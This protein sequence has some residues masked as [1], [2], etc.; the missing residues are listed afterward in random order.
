M[1]KAD[2][3]GTR[4]MWVR[5][6]VAVILLLLPTAAFAQ[7]EKRIALLIGNKNYQPAVGALKNPHNDIE[8][9]SAALDAI[10]FKDRITH[11]DLRRG[12]LL[13]AVS[14]YA[15]RLAAAG[16]RAIGFLYYSGHGAAEHGTNI[17]YIIPV[18]AADPHS[19]SFWHESVQLEE[20]TRLILDR[21]PQAAHFVVF[22]ACRNELRLS[23]KTATKG[24]VPVQTLRGMFV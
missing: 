3:G 17:N 16:P 9:I 20:V 1:L 12:Q 6:V 19:V 7:T 8:V 21:A 4:T 13:V 10:G 15:A 18:D 2:L 5:V 11:K 14:Q 22:D 23:D 24:F